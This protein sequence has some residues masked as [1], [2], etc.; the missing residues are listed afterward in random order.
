[1]N[2]LHTYDSIQRIF[3]KKMRH[4]DLSPAGYAAL[5][6]AAMAPVPAHAFVLFKPAQGRVFVLQDL[7]T[8][9]V[10]VAGTVTGQATLSVSTGTPG[11][12]DLWSSTLAAPV[13][14]TASITA[15]STTATVTSATGLSNGQTIVGTGIPAGTTYTIS[16]TTLTLSQAA[17]ATNAAASLTSY[18]V[19]AAVPL[20]ASVTLPYNGGAAPYGQNQVLKHTLL[21][22]AA[23][24]FISHQNPLC[25]TMT[26]GAT[27]AT[28]F[29]VDFLMK[30]MEITDDNFAPPNGAP[31]IT[32]PVE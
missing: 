13:P 31:S 24:T 27:G 14:V 18:T 3:T 22:A 7:W 28:K 9:N 5:P 11:A 25:V 21:T 15:S 6:S 2:N 10:A 20:V 1:M 30:L 23:T 17:T 8:I 12:G 4:I 19:A 32:V 16:G 29:D 26:Q